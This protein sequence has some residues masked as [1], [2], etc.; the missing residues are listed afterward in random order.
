MTFLV[1]A[2]KCSLKNSF[3]W[4][5]QESHQYLGLTNKCECHICERWKGRSGKANVGQ[6]HMRPWI[7]WRSTDL[8]CNF[9]FV[10]IWRKW[11]NTWICIF[12]FICWQIKKKY[13][14]CLLGSWEKHSCKS[15]SR[16]PSLSF[17]ACGWFKWKK[18]ALQSKW[19]SCSNLTWIFEVRNAKI[20][21]RPL[22]LPAWGKKINPDDNHF[23]T[24][25][26]YILRKKRKLLYLS[27]WLLVNNS[28]RTT[29]MRGCFILNTTQSGDMTWTF[30]DVE[31]QFFWTFSNACPMLQ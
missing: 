21:I 1:D 29:V 14:F 28:I 25:P 20:Y 22:L 30:P 23:R 13:P 24:W 5:M 8:L 27:S 3:N 19:Q 12:Q 4:N 17:I 26:D 18:V 9:W 15:K 7:T 10:N 16:F 11:G 6:W 2:P 31:K